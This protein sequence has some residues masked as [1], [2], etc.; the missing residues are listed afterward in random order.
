MIQRIQTF[1]MLVIVVLSAI[2]LFSDLGGLQNQETGELFTLSYRGLFEKDV[3]ND[4]VFSSSVWLLT[5]LMVIIPIISL[6]AVF[7]FKRRLLQIRLL[8]FNL[9]LMAGFYGLLFIYLWQFGKSTETKMYLEMV[10]AFPLVN[11]ILSVLAI[12]AIGKD[13]ALIKSLNRIR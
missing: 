12:R 10:T 1:Y 3:T 4:L 2:T 13:E 6:I 5:A 9:V 11:I 7:L 8:I